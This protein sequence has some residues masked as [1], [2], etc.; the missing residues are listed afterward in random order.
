MRSDSRR[1]RRAAGFRAS[2][3]LVLSLGLSAACATDVVEGDDSRYFPPRTGDGSN[4]QTMG[5]PNDCDISGYWIG[6]FFGQNEALGMPTA[7]HNWF[8]YEFIDHG[9]EVEIVR[10]W[11]CGY[12]VCGGM[13]HIE[14]SDEQSIMYA[15]RNRQDGEL[16]ADPVDPEASFRVAPRD[17]TFKKREDGLCEFEMSRWWWVRSGGTD[18]YPDREDFDTMT[19]QQIQTQRPLDPPGTP[20][21]ADNNWDGDEHAGVTLTIDKPGGWRA[22]A[23][24]DWNEFGPGLVIDGAL[25][26]TIPAWFDNEEVN[27]AVSMPLL[28]Q[29]S[30][31]YQNGN[32]IRFVRLPNAAPEDL[33]GFV[34]YCRDAFQTYFRAPGTENNCNIIKQTAPEES[35][36]PE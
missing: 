2:L 27:Y 11:D 30:T 9:D 4:H 21:N 19:I 6:Q 20:P 5:P 16:K 3:A 34:S 22:S 29:L 8:Y 15:Q 25:D 32:S 31:P 10:G 12:Q 14:L 35:F 24:R 7:A 36:M 1:R 13:V 26:F 17:F 28:D 18:R 33:P 23:Q